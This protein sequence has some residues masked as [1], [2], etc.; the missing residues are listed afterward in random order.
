[1]ATQFE[2]WMVGHDAGFLQSVALQAWAELDRLEL[3]LS[4][5]DQRA[6]VARINREGGVRPVRIEVELFKILKDCQHWC[7][8]TQGYFNI[9]MAT[10][11]SPGA[12]MILDEQ[13]RSVYLE[14]EGCFLDLGGYGKGYALDVIAGMIKDYGVTSA[15]VQGGTSSAL[16]WGENESERWR[17]DIAHF[18]DKEHVIFKK[19]L[20][21]CGF[22]YSATRGPEKREAGILNPVTGAPMIKPEACWV[23][24]STALEAE[25][26]TTAA[27]AM[28]RDRARQFLKEFQ[29]DT[30]EVGWL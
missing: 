4:R 10:Q 16:A 7:N 9:C 2:L 15:F 6:E 13:N 22:S 19:D 27:L 11:Q 17:V 3:L 25:V 14:G 23:I 5:F 30:M 1:M 18:M 8:V 26:I 28:G 12:S 24:A 20:Q 29:K 21:N